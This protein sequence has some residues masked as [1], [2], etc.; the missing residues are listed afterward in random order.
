MCVSCCFMKPLDC[1]MNCILKIMWVNSVFDRP[2]DSTR[3]L[4]MNR[5]DTY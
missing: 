5:S 1:A 3:C 2:V 4:I